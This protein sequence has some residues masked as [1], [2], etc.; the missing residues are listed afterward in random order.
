MLF[1]DE[2]E[3]ALSSRD[4]ARVR[5]ALRTLAQHADHYDTWPLQAPPL[6]VLD[7]FDG[8]VPEEVA[9]DLFRIWT[10]WTEF[11]PPWPEAL[12][13]CS[14]AELVARVPTAGVAYA[15]ALELRVSDPTGPALPIA[16]GAVVGAE[17]PPQAQLAMLDHLLDGGPEVRQATLEAL[18]ARRDAP[19]AA[20]VRHALEEALTPEERAA[21][22]R[23]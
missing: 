9:M 12:R 22:E 20:R 13:W 1:E 15:V 18:A 16:V 3:P 2:I 10:A 4:P 23:Q 17:D 5:E 14:L 11:D 6:S 19:G 21:L 7:A 8:P